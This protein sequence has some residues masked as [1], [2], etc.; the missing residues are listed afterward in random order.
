MSKN[1]P[2]LPE[3]ELVLSAAARLQE[4][5]PDAVLVG[6]TASAIYGQE[7]EESPL[8][9]LQVQLAKPLPFDLE[10]TELREYKNL[11]PRWHDWSAV[12]AVC[13]HI[14]TD[15]FDRVC[16]LESGCAKPHRK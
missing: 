11:A 7:N 1:T 8:Q 10:A 6:G 15:V 3:W 9:Q 14:A 16:E 5:L 4:L 12:E 13:V 2:R